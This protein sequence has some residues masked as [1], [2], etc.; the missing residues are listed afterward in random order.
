[1]HE[2]T[3]GD[4]RIANLAKIAKSKSEIAA[5]RQHL[6]DVIRSAA[7]QGSQRSG[8]FLEYIVEHALAGQL[9]SLKE[10]VIGMELFRRPPSYD[11]GEDSIVRVTA[12]DVRRRLL[13]HYG[14]FGVSSEIRISLPTGSYVPEITWERDGGV[15]HSVA[16]QANQEPTIALHSSPSENIESLPHARESSAVF[17]P[18]PET[19]TEHSKGPIRRRWLTLGVTL[20]MLS[21]ALW[22][23]FRL[24]SSH[25]SDAT[26]SVQPWSTF[27]SSPRPLHLITSDPVIFQV[28]ELTGDQISLP[29]Y[30]NHNYISDPEK[31]SPE[32]KKLSDNILKGDK[33]ASATDPPIAAEIAA[34]AQRNS[35]TIDVRAAR[36]IQF[37]DLKNDDNFIFLGSPSSNPWSALF[38]DQ[39]DFRFVF[40]KSS[41]Q[42][43]IR[44]I[45]PY[46]G[47]PSTYAP[48][49]PGWATGQSYAIVAFIH[50]PDQ[51][52]RVLLIAGMNGEGTEAAGK[53]VIDL[54]RL[55][56]VL[57]QCGIAPSSP[58]REF[59]ILLQLNTLAGSPHQVDVSACHLISAVS[60]H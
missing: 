12:S 27:F 33:S 41:R 4:E 58:A 28:E 36:N 15:G 2:S 13:Q 50:N 37:S 55:T 24:R 9:D 25:P 6:K 17:P 43:I 8:K 57:R 49:A 60:I 23:I 3:P 44:N 18:S 59:E 48:T 53:L 14:M 31:L 11:T 16:V 45:H 39:L 26:I 1:M 54:P 19:T 34:L 42:E 46:Q 22:G 40:D 10:R 52:G 56:T 20:G 30:A 35:R 51:G 47:E 7:F 32:I 38:S 5:V 29:D 21:L